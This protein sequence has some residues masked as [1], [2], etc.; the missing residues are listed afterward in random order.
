MLPAYVD[1]IAL[2]VFD[3]VKFA[4]NPKTKKSGLYGPTRWV[5]LPRD[6]KRFDDHMQAVAQLVAHSQPPRS[7]R[8]CDICKLRLQVDQEDGVATAILT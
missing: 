7:D 1:G 6:Q 8:N 2:L 3:P 4:F 5:E